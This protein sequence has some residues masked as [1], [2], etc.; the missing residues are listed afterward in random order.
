MTECVRDVG[1]DSVCYRQEVRL[2][3][4]CE[5]RV[6]TE[7]RGPAARADDLRQPHQGDDRREAAVP[8]GLVAAWGGR[9]AQVHRGLRRRGGAELQA[10]CLAAGQWN[11][12]S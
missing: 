3:E 4:V 5:R 8:A 6:S 10:H 11:A 9:Q 7:G 1:R 2:R 12:V